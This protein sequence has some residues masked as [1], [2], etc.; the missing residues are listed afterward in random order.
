MI[1]DTILDT[2]G[3]TPVVRLHRTGPDHVTIYVKV[4]SFNPMASVKDRLAY[5]IIKDARD[6]GALKPGQTVVEATSGN[7]GIALAMVCAVYGHPFV[8]TMAETFSVERRRL[9]RAFGAKVILTPAAERGSGMVRR[10]EELAKKHG[11]FLARQFENPAN[12]AYHRNT[13]GP[14]ILRDFAGKRLD[15]WVTGWGTGGTL[16]G[17]GEVLKVARPNVKVIVVEPAGAAMLSG[18]EWKPHKIQGWTP[19]FI[20]GVLNKKVGDEF[21]SVEDLVARDTALHLAQKE[22]IFV[23]ISAG[24]TLAGALDVAKR[25]PKGSVMLVMLPDTGE[26]YLSTILF[27]GIPEGSDDDWL[28]SLG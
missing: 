18:K 17:V 1:Y 15:Y 24:A 16:T 12:P 14:E 7:T 25:A 27:E 8:A 6:S 3:N 13:T 26:R 28:A 4:E 5:A 2:I 19:D 20:P 23:G 9:M 11:W 22:G 10:A 21:V